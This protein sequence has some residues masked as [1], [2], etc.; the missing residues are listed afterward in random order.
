MEYTVINNFME[1]GQMLHNA[2][3]LLRIVVP[4]PLAV[5]LLISLIFPIWKLS[6]PDPVV[7]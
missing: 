7:L 6:S 3:Y 1:V 2:S 4:V 5:L